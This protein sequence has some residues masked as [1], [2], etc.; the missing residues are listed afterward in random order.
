MFRYLRSLFAWKEV[1]SAGV[2]RYAENAVTGQRRA[3]RVVTGV[4]SPV[5]FDW[6]DDGIGHPIINGFPAWRSAPGQ[7]SGRYR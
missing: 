3:D 6:L 1:R 2:W 4:V 5:D 7:L